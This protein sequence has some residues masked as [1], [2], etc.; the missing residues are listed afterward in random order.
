MTASEATTGTTAV[1]RE[2]SLGSARL[3]I[4]PRGTGPAEPA[5]YVGWDRRPVCGAD[6]VS[7]TFP[8][9]RLSSVRHA[10]EDCVAA[11]RA[12]SSARLAG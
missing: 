11:T 6:Q 7:Y 3:D 4:T 10:C 1:R 5:H 9:R 8:G 2:L 12:A